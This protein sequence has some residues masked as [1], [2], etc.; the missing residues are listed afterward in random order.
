ML[1]RV[2]IGRKKS[3]RKHRDKAR[4]REL[5]KIEIVREK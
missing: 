2:F 3:A 4:E 1:V 5:I